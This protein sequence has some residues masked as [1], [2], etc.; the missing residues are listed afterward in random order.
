MLQQAHGATTFCR[1]EHISGRQAQWEK[2]GGVWD[3]HLK[4]QV[5]YWVPKRGDWCRAPVDVKEGTFIPLETPAAIRSS[6]INSE[7]YIW[8]PVPKVE[9]CI[10]IFVESTKGSLGLQRPDHFPCFLKKPPHPVPSP[11]EACKNVYLDLE[12][13]RHSMSDKYLRSDLF[14]EGPSKIIL[15]RRGRVENC[16]VGMVVWA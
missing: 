15:S 6:R 13:G 1:V 2:F 14:H 16:K 11:N 4:K 7:E 10:V 12:W 3:R 9:Y 8:C 5:L